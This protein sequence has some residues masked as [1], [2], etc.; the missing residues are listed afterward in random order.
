LDNLG[1]RGWERRKGAHP[2]A[3]AP[4][5]KEYIHPISLFNN[6]ILVKLLNLYINEPA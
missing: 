6:L 1:E 3:D 2:G 4:V 5:I